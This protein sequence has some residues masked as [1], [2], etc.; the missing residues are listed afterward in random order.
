VAEASLSVLADPHRDIGGL[1][2]LA[3]DGGQVISDRV[4][5]HR[6]L[7]PGRER[8]QCCVSVTPGPVEPPV[9]WPDT[10]S[11]NMRITSNAPA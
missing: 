10:E 5:V 4:Q 8:G 2:G 6:V 1:Q 9:H 7:E 11:A 3:D